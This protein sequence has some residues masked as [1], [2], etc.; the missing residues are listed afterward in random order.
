MTL[1]FDYIPQGLWVRTFLSVVFSDN[2]IRQTSLTAYPRS[3]ESLRFCQNI[4]FCKIPQFP[5]EYPR[6][7]PG[8][9]DFCPKRNLTYLNLISTRLLNWEMTC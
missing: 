9:E 7:V 3:P 1:Q 4:S 8:Q 5:I 6:L 2:R